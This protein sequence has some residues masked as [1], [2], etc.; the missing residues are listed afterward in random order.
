MKLFGGGGHRVNNSHTGANP[1]S[2]AQKAYEDYSLFDDE[3]LDL[4]LELETRPQARP[5][6]SH[7]A[8]ADMADDWQP[9]LSPSQESR[10]AAVQTAP[11]PAAAVPARP[12]P[13]ADTAQARPSVQRGVE[14]AR[15][16]QLGC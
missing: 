8:S 11:Q 4:S 7:A 3:S 12:R 1:R 6:S 14:L 9:I 15:A 16:V 5:Q 13:A 2:A 10:P